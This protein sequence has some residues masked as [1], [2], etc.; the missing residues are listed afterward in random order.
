MAPKPR[1]KMIPPPTAGGSATPEDLSDFEKLL[2]KAIEDP[3]YAR[4]LMSC[5]GDALEELHIDVT[6]AKLRALAEC[7]DPLCEAYEAFGGIK[8]LIG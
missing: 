3:N 8:R 7:V 4:R 6:Q 5:P 2:Q 1:G